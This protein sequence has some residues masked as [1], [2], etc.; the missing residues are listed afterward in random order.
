MKQQKSTYEANVKDWLES[1]RRIVIESIIHEDQRYETTGDWY[2]QRRPDREVELII[3]VSF[4]ADWRSDMAVALHEL[5]EAILCVS[6]EVECEGPPVFDVGESP[7]DAFDK[8]FEEAREEMQ[9]DSFDFRGRTCAPDAEP[10]D[11]HD[12]PYYHQHQ[13]ATTIERIFVDKLGMNWHE[14]IS[15]QEEIGG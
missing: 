15:H 3:L 14:H 6:D 9:G 11:Q 5:V 2:F 7:C 8:N 4:T 1:S 13:A 12:A 10:G